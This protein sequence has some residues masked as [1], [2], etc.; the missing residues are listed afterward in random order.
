M[1]I[2]TV[3]IILMATIL[4]ILGCK[5]RNDPITWNESRTDKWF[6]QGKW[7]NSW[8]VTPDSTINK[9]EMAVEYFRHAERW[10]KAF[11]FLKDSDLLK[12][13]TG[14]HDIDDDNL[15]A[16]VSEYNTKNDDEANWEAHRK[17]A[18]IQYVI[19]GTEMI[20]VAPYNS[21]DSIIQE[22]DPVQDIEFMTVKDGNKHEASPDNFFVF[23]PDNAHKP[24]LKT[25]S[26]GMVRKIV[27]KV[28]ID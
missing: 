11:T 21:R 5:D 22:Y 15:Y 9:K 26:T 10:N 1:R 14:R 13:E 4:S 28:R 27:L 18:D 12:L 7:L 16:M 20:G 3:K 24:G 6:N 23:F 19:E 17:Y 8:S 2:L 25:D